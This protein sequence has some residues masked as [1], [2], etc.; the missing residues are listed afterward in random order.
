MHDT[1]PLHDGL[2]AALQQ[3]IAGCHSG[4]KGLKF[5]HALLRVI[6]GIKADAPLEPAA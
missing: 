2:R 1:D 6:A 3:G 5:L 4:D